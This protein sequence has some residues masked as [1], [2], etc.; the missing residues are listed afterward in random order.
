[1]TAVAWG[2]W[3][4]AFGGM[5]DQGS[6]RSE[7]FYLGKQNDQYLWIAAGKMLQPRYGHASLVMDSRTI[8]H[9]GGIT[10]P[11]SNTT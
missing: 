6:I 1:M 9:F 10:D 11:T 2:A 5:S 3:V 4:Y 8:H 7:A